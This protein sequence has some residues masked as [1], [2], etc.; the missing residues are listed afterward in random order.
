MCTFGELYH[1]GVPTELCFEISWKCCDNQWKTRHSHSNQGAQAK[2]RTSKVSKKLPMVERKLSDSQS[3]KIHARP[4]SLGDIPTW[5]Q[6]QIE[7]IF[8]N[9]R[10][11]EYRNL[12][13]W[14]TIVNYLKQAAKCLKNLESNE[15]DF[16]MTIDDG[17]TTAWRRNAPYHVQCVKVQSHRGNIFPTM[18]CISCSQPW[19]ISDCAWKLS[20]SWDLFLFFSTPS[21]VILRS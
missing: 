8:P 9:R 14:C 5:F 19:P 10:K 12:H 7:G 1:S 17:L 2:G 15:N 6:R 13:M 20:C 11:L 3:H 18:N 4:W 16:W 21:R